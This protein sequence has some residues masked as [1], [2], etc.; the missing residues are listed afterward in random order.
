[1]LSKLFATV[2]LFVSLSSAVAPLAHAERASAR[3]EIMEPAPDIAVVMSRENVRAALVERR[4]QNLAAFRAYVAA[5]VYPSNT[6]QPNKLNVW[7]DRD[8]HFCAAATIIRRSGA[9]AL[10]DKVAEQTNYIKLADVKQ[11]PVMDWILTSGFTQDEIAMIQEPFEPV[12]RPKT[13]QVDRGMRAAETARL[14]TRYAAIDKALVQGEQAALDAATDRLMKNPEL[15]YAV[16][17]NGI[18]D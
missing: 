1:M 9:V 13:V 10:V 12:A 2:T 3:D 15:A 6:F 5:G 7:K 17:D 18:D 14:R 16:L 11:G 4:A 8:G